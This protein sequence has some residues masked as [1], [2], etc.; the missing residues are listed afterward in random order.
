[1]FLPTNTALCYV[2]GSTRK[3]EEN[4][5]SSETGV[6]VFLLSVMW[7]LGTEPG[8]SARATRALNHNC[9]LPFSSNKLLFVHLFD[10]F[11]FCMTDLMP[12]ILR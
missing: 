6:T 12:E 8:S 11:F 5:R 7:V 1:M 10:F 3:L 2:Q 9:D 4:I